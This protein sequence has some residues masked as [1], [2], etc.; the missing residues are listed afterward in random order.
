[1]LIDILSKGLSYGNV[2][3]YLQAPIQSLRRL[4][5]QFRLFEGSR[6]AEVFF[7]KNCT[8]L[9]PFFKKIAPVWYRRADAR[10]GQ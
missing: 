6:D 8:F 4:Y 2:L 7:E 10:T 1:M 5:C 9:G 3:F